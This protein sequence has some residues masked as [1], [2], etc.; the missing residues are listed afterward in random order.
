MNLSDFKAVMLASLRSLIPKAWS[1]VP[2]RECDGEDVE[3]VFQK[4]QRFITKVLVL[5]C[6]FNDVVFIFILPT[7]AWK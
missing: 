7:E 6:G 5:G 3:D 2:W 4:K 1:D